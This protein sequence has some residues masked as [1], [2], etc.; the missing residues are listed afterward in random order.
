MKDWQGAD[1]ICYLPLDSPENAKDFLEIINPNSIFFIKYEYWLFF[2]EEIKKRHTPAFLI[3][4]TFK[5]H[6]PFFR[7]YGKIFR[8]SLSAF[9]ILF[10]QDQ[11]SCELLTKIGINNFVLSGDT[12]IDRVL[13]IRADAEGIPVLEEFKGKSKLLIAGSSW[14][15]DEAL[16]IEAFS[17]LKKQN[18]KL[19]IV[20]HNLHPGL[21]K[22]TA[23]K[24][25]RYDLNFC[26]YSAGVNFDSD[27]LILDTMGLLSRAYVYADLVHIGGGF[28]HGIH[29]ILEPAV[30]GIPVCISGKGHEKY[31]EA[32]TLLNRGDLKLVQNS[33]EFSQYAL[34]TLSNTKVLDR[35]K[36]DLSA[37]FKENSNVTKRIF[38]QIDGLAVAAK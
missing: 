6:Q 24:L 31:N 38:D 21:Q 9:R 27:V 4:A 26:F 34:D 25:K 16:V 14:P 19:V 37:Y 13:K 23:A 7:W 12:R 29:N 5:M 28:D 11:S 8:S 1:L 2:L 17:Q 30:F 15:K 22:E 36:E 20:P 32:V 3:S 35:I 33:E 10:L 18:L